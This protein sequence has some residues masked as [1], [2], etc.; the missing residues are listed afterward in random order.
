MFR[1]V[2]YRPGHRA[3]F[4][5]LNRAWIAQHFALE[6]A[7]EHALLDPETHFLARG[8]QIVI[9]EAASDGETIGSGARV[10]H[11]DALEVSKMVVAAAWRGRG[12][13]RALLEE[14]IRRFEASG[15]RELFLET[16]ASLRPALALYAS[17]GFRQ[18][19]RRRPG[20]PYAR[21]DVHMVWQP[22]LRR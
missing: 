5:A 18:V 21:A 14:L 12:I 10:A 13:G 16:S 8:G 11:D 19:G 17:L 9:A 1:V 22:A 7:D 15:A 2:N 3:A 4:A 6:P 20:S